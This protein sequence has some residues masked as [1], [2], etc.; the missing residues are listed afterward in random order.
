MVVIMMVGSVW[1]FKTKL[2]NWTEICQELF[3]LLILYHLFI[4]TDMVGD[5]E[6]RYNAGFGIIGLTLLSIVINSL[7][8][9][10]GTYQ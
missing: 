2:A 10:R 4:F 6:T 3:V 8:L 9:G 7:L 5:V 1:P